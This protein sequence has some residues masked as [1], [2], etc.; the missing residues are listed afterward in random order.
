M[1]GVRRRMGES[2]WVWC[3]PEKPPERKRTDGEH[4]ILLN[5]FPVGRNVRL[6]LENV[7]QRLARN[8][9]G[10]VLDLL[11]VGSYVYAADQAVTR[12]G[13]T[14]RHNGSDWRRSFRFDI[15]VRNLDLWN[16]SE[17]QEALTETLNFLSDETFE[18]RFHKL[19]K[20]VPAEAYFNFDQ[21]QP[22][23]EADEVMLYSGGLDS[24][25]G[26]CSSTIRD[27]KKVIAVSHRAAPQIY[28]RQR[29]LLEEFRR[30]NDSSTKVLHIPVWVNKGE[31]LTR[32][33]DQRTRSFLFVM[34]AAAVAEMQGLSSVSF[35]EN[36]ITSSNL[37]VLEQLMG[38]RAS[39]S[40]HPK[41]LNDFGKLLSL[42]LGRQFRVV[43]PMFW[44]TK[45]DIVQTIIDLGQRDLIKFSNSCSKV[46]PSDQIKTHCGICSQCVDRRF[47]TLAVQAGESDPEEIYGVLLPTDPL[48]TSD[49]RTVAES[50]VRFAKEV[51]AMSIDEFYTKFGPAWDVAAEL[52]SQYRMQHRNSSTS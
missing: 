3:G 12:G 43:D 44:K 47:A 46:R 1:V 16:S 33:V 34:L 18:F 31:D 22:W 15:P 32:D 23:F 5:T 8:L 20:D 24:L 19:K 27:G 52:T 9:S 41:V 42:L 10:L 2:R 25:A 26:L 21:G 30:E 40:T 4:L 7:S 36:G 11:E 38:A 51:K 50:Y 17:V 39:R 45:A 37:S 13:R 35:Y 14:L 28:S 29:I 6:N 49:G 48:V